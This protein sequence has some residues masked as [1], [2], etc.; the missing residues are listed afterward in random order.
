MEYGETAEDEYEDEAEG[1]EYFG[2][3]AAE[4]AAAGYLYHAAG[5]GVVGAGES[6]G[7][8]LLSAEGFDGADAGKRFF[9]ECEEVS[10]SSLAFGSVAAKAFADETDEPYGGGHDEEEIEEEARAD[11]N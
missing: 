4:F 3:R 2:E 8:L 1:E 11:E 5:V 9:E 6:V 10:E 7:G